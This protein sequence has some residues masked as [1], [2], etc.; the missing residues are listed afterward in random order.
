MASHFCF[1][2][3]FL[4]LRIVKSTLKDD[5]SAPLIYHDP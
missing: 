3:V 2:S 4:F 1:F 5:T